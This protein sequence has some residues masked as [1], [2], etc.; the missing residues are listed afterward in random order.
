MSVKLIAVDM[1]G[2]FLNDHMK[3]DKERFLNQFSIMKEKGIK[4][5]VASGNQYYQLISFFPEIR[6]EIAFVSENGAKI[7][8][9]NKELYCAELSKDKVEKVLHVL[10][11]I[12][13]KEYVM[14]GSNSAYVHR[15]IS[16]AAYELTKLYYYKLKKVD[17]LHAVEDTIFK[18]CTDFK[19]KDLDE[20]IQHL[21][22]VLEG[23]MIPV[24]TGH[25]G[26][27]FIIP[28]VHK[29]NGIKRLQEHWGIKDD[30]VAA[31]GDSGNDYEMLKHAQYSYA[32]GNAHPRI[33]KVA[34][35]VIKTN[36][37]SGVLEQID[38]LLAL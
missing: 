11:N 32:M 20:V 12:N 30:E 27:D 31:F 10:E 33:K 25:D 14:C 5:V 15:D 34:K 17:D 16:D 3:Y 13:P 21:N 37:E 7:V 22:Q 29:A 28:G 26:V 6:D 19:N 38:K 23:I 35:Q 24:S 4:F 36:N 18:F 9:C 1:D 2:T 8:D